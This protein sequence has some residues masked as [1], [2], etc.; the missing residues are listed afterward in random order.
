LESAFVKVKDAIGNCVSLYF[1]D[2][3]GQIF[4]QTDASDF[5]IGGYIYQIVNGTSCDIF[6]QGAHGHSEEMVYS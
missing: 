4:V 3:E 5:G 1:V 6:Q 2:K